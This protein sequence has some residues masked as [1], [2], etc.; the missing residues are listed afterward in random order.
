MIRHGVLLGGV[1]CLGILAGCGDDDDT[2][3]DTVASTSGDSTA[4]TSEDSA[5]SAPDDSTAMPVPDSDGGTAPALDGREFVSTGIEGHDLVPGS[6][7]RITFQDGSLSANAGCNTMGG[8]YSFDGATLQVEAMAM[9]EMACDEE[10]MA[11][12]TFVIELLTGGPTVE[13]DGD[14]LTIASDDMTLTMLDR[15]VAEPDLSLE[16]VTWQLESIITGD[17]VSSVPAGVESTLAFFDDGTVALDTGCNSG[18]GDVEVGDGTLTFGP[19]ATTLRFCEG[20]A[21]EVE[22]AVTTTLRGEVAYTI[23]ADVLSIRADDGSG[24]DYRTA[25]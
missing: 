17:S 2:V 6:E 24:L 3:D 1:V 5:V 18:G 12:D 23:D 21:G 22:T 10:L 11:Q 16:G 7:L 20:G 13:L 19:L 14:V 8:G 9:T 4:S 25:E 15:E